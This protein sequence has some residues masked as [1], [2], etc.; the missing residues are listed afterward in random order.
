MAGAAFS[1]QTPTVGAGCLNWARPD[2][3]GGRPE[4]DV[5][6]A[7]GIRSAR[8]YRRRTLIAHGRCERNQR[9]TNTTNTARAHPRCS[10]YNPLVLDANTLPDDV[11]TLKRLVLERDREV[12]HLK[13]QLAKLCRWKFGQS[14]ES[15][16][17]AGQLPL[18]LE[19]LKAAVMQ[20]VL[21]NAASPEPLAAGSERGNVIPLKKRPKRRK[22]LP[23]HFES[24]E[25]RIEPEECVRGLRR[26]VQAPRQA[27]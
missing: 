12:E 7:I 3:C 6:T 13:L 18:R 20:A 27:R 1:R 8:D 21:E 24:I 2:L 15:L 14:S 16:K 5:P 10:A 26:S 19:E 23:E 22:H 17:E 4:R 25:N 11:A 9:T